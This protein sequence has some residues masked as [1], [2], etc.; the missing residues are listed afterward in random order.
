MDLE[1]RISQVGPLR[2]KKMI[3]RWLQPPP[4]RA[5][6]SD[7]CHQRDSGAACRLRDKRVGATM[8]ASRTRWEPS[9]KCLNAG[10]SGLASKER[11]DASPLAIGEERSNDEH[12]DTLA[13]T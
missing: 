9:G 1:R 8:R 4:R 2:N 7:I 12:R 5:T 3:A 11:V 13:R 6:L 10:C